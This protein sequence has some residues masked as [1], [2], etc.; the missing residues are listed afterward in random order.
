MMEG[1]M[2]GYAAAG[3]VLSTVVGG[4]RSSD[5]RTGRST[6]RKKLPDDSRKIVPQLLLHLNASTS[7]LNTM[8]MPELAQ[9]LGYSVG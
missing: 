1:R 9:V 7:I 6:D 8:Q 3:P 5:Y 4:R 2:I